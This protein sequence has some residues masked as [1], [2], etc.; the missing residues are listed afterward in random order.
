MAIKKVVHTGSGTSVNSPKELQDK[1][2]EPTTKALISKMSDEI[3]RHMYDLT[4]ERVYDAYT[5]TNYERTGEFLES[6]TKE[7]G[8]IYGGNIFQAKVYFDASKIKPTRSP[9][10]GQW[11][12]HMGLQGQKFTGG[13]VDVIVD[14]AD[15]LHLLDIAGEGLR[16]VAG[17]LLAVIHHSDHLEGAF[18]VEARVQ[19]V[20]GHLAEGGQD[21]GIAGGHDGGAAAVYNQRQHNGDCGDH[22]RAD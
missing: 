15:H 18:Q 5:P 7:K 14:R 2:L 17:F 21:A 19:R 10:S 16:V 13:L 12:Q 4:Q 8:D 11:N 1:V 22:A 3:Y 20:V 9:V 6:L